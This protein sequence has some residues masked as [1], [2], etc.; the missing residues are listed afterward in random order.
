MWFLLRKCVVSYSELCVVHF[1]FVIQI[2]VIQICVKPMRLVV[3]YI[4]RIDIRKSFCQT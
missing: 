4:M 1:I 3:P 2:L